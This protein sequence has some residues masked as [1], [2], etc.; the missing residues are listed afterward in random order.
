MG[1]KKKALQVLM[2]KMKNVE[3]AI[4]F[5]KEENEKY[6]WEMLISNACDKAEFITSLL[7]NIGSHV[8]PI[9]IIRQIKGGMQIP[10]LRDSLVKLLQDYNLRINLRRGC[11]NILISDSIS[12]FQK[13]NS[14]RRRSI[15]VLGMYF[16]IYR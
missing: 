9:F 8:D 2:N 4:I 7:N 10:G 6:L 11:R 15:S 13:L 1:N 3:E 16:D 12:L 14:L 5:C